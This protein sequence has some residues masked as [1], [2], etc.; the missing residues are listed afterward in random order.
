LYYIFETLLFLKTIIIKNKLI[1]KHSEMQKELVSLLK[2]VAVVVA[3]VLIANAIE[4]KYMSTKTLV[5][6]ETEV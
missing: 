6:L 2:G 5:P 4:K 1:K 3:G